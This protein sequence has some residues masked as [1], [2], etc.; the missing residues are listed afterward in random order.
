MNYELDGLEIGGSIPSKVRN[1]S[2]FYSVQTE[3][4]VHLTS[5]VMSTVGSFLKSKAA[6]T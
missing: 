5:Y 6:G 3:S 2:P 1:S 4:E